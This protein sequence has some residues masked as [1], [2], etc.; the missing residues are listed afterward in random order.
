MVESWLASV[1]CGEQ[2]REAA[3]EV[4]QGTG[5]FGNIRMW[6]WAG[7]FRRTGACRW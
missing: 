2:N 3:V 7:S 4:I 1:K 5:L 6:R